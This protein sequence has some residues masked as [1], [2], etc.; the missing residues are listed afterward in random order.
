ME[1]SA[2]KSMVTASTPTAAK[3]LEALVPQGIVKAIHPRT[4]QPAKMLG[5]GTKGGSVRTTKIY[6]KRVQQFKKKVHRFRTLRNCGFATRYAVQATAMPAIGYGLETAGISDTALRQLRCMVNHAAGTATGGGNFEEELMARDALHGRLDPAFDAH[7]KPI[8]A[9]A[10]AWWNNWRSHQQLE[11]SFSRAHNDLQGCQH[12]SQLWQRVRGPTAAAIATASRIGWHFASARILHTDDGCTFD[13]VRDPPAA[14]VQAVHAAV[15][16]WRTANVLQNHTATM[17]LLQSPKFDAPSNVL[18]C[19]YDNWRRAKNM[20]SVRTGL[21]SLDNAVNGKKH[22]LHTDSWKRQY[23]SYLASAMSNKQWTQARCAAARGAGWTKDDTCRLCNAAPGTE[24]HRHV[25]PAIWTTPQQLP[26]PAAQRDIFTRTQLQRDLWRTRG[27]G[28]TRVFVPQRHTDERVE[29]IKMPPE[30]IDYQVL[31]WYVDASQIDAKTETA[32]R[33]GIGA[34]AVNQRGDLVAAMRAIPPSRITSIPAAEAWAISAVLQ[35]TPTR[36][37]VFTDCKSNLAILARGRKW[38]TDGKR[39]NART[40]Q[41][42]FHSLDEDQAAI[43]AIVWMPAHKTREQVGKVVKSDG[44]PVNIVDWIGNMAADEL[45]KSAANS[46]RVPYNVLRQL[47]DVEAAAAYWRCTLGETTYRAQN[48]QVQNILPDGTITTTVKRDSDGKPPGNVKHPDE[49]A[50]QT[51]ATPEAREAASG[52]KNPTQPTPTLTASMAAANVFKAEVTAAMARWR[53]IRPKSP[54]TGK[55]HLRKNF[56]NSKA[57]DPHHHPLN[58]TPTVN[59]GCGISAEESLRRREIA[60]S[61]CNAANSAIMASEGSIQHDNGRGVYRWLW[62]EEGGEQPPESPTITEHF[63]I[64]SDEDTPN[65]RNTNAQH[66]ERAPDPRGLPRHHKR[67]ISSTSIRPAHRASSS[68]TPSNRREI[69]T[70]HFN[71]TSAALHAHNNRGLAAS[72]R[73]LLGKGPTTHT[74]TNDAPRG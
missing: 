57:I 64:C 67:D 47:N 11:A 18:H 6:C 30:D 25:C 68:T 73:R 2:S 62:K 4:G 20:V 49:K 58:P 23:A 29:W 9:W 27:I 32:V 39:V 15:I 12:H 44:S 69:P 5:V 60:T 54:A 43:D 34:V 66:A 59:V 48:F 38:A 61:L 51:R 19:A 10:T 22:Q 33:F 53:K 46:D 72:I 3:L 41:S 42:I 37:R 26:S 31:D 65:V 40:W 56:A 17:T 21:S 8:A 71:G 50:R 74:S 36:R 13:L 7:A 28:G 1:V 70:Y 24:A 52:S 63:V 14:V 35:V 55:K 45:A 16:R